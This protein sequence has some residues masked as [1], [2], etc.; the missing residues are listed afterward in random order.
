MLDWLLV[1]VHIYFLVFLFF[2]GFL[3]VCFFNFIVTGLNIN[4]FNQ[5]YEILG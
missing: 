5:M 4:E 2:N 1:L 3:F